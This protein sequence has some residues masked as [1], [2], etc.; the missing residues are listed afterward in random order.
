MH[1][2]HS[3]R[4][5]TNI[6]FLFSDVGTRRTGTRKLRNFEYSPYVDSWIRPHFLRYLQAGP[7]HVHVGLWYYAKG[8]FRAIHHSHSM[9]K[10]N[11]SALQQSDAHRKENI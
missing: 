7:L 5:R 6:D 9:S 3:S 2:S 10:E 1:D 4:Q 11:L 8:D